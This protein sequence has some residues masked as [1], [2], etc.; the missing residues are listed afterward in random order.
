M[1]TVTQQM[2]TDVQSPAEDPSKPQ[3][4][5]LSILLALGHG[6]DSHVLQ[7]LACIDENTAC[8]RCLRLVSKEVGRHALFA[9]RTYTVTLQGSDRDTNV[10]GASLLQQA[11]LNT[12]AVRL[13]L[14][15]E[16]LECTSLIVVVAAKKEI[17]VCT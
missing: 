14:T 4:L 16:R 5:D 6:G 1:C 12:L 9:L 2:E 17:I 10:S 8:L 3:H 13:R 15:G 7:A 11:R